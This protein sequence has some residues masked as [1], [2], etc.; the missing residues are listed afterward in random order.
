[1]S[2]APA[3]APVS[4]YPPERRSHRRFSIALTATYRVVR[5]GRADGWT[6]AR[7]INIASRG[8]LLEANAS[9]TGGTPIE[10]LIDWP[11]RLEG[12]CP[13]KLLVAGRI[14]RSDVKG[15]AIEAKHY[16]FRTAGIRKSGAQLRE[17][18]VRS[19]HE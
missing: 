2:S 13:L 9:L 16:E 10:L 5:R 15:V 1:M 14:I 19:F 3:A 11:L 8:V 12:V 7:T 18:K 17:L 4:P 6:S